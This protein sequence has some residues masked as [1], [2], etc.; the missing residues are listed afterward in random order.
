MVAQWI[1]RGF[2]APVCIAL[3]A[4]P[5]VRKPPF[6]ITAKKLAITAVR[7]HPRHHLTVYWLSVFSDV[8]P[9]IIDHMID[10]F[11]LVDRMAQHIKP[12][13]RDP[14]VVTASTLRIIVK[15]AFLASAEK[16][17]ARQ[18]PLPS[19]QLGTATAGPGTAAFA[20]FRVVIDLGLVVHKGGV[21]VMVRE[22]RVL[23]IEGRRRRVPS[24]IKNS[25]VKSGDHEAL[26]TQPVVQRPAVGH[27]HRGQRFPTAWYHPGGTRGRSRSNIKL[28]DP[29]VDLVAGDLCRKQAVEGHGIAAG[30]VI[31][32]RGH[33]PDTGIIRTVG[34]VHHLHGGQR[35][36]ARHP[37]R[38]P[39]GIRRL[40]HR[41]TVQQ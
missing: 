9:I 15:C 2:V 16:P 10:V 36:D 32:H 41:R 3:G 40:R 6:V 27:P 26:T 12:V 28:H 11:V 33:F 8:Q 29:A 5:V 14:V 24:G 1:G 39:D 13:A 19:A 17:I 31:N 20:D 25:P 21:D 18:L 23:V 35:L 37:G 7:V 22:P 4:V 30:A 38:H 34:P